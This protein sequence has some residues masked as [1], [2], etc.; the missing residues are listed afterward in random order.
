MN[1]NTVAVFYFRLSLNKGQEVVK[2]VN[3]YVVA[4]GVYPFAGKFLFSVRY[5]I[6]VR[7]DYFHAVGIVAD[8]LKRHHNAAFFLSKRRGYGSSADTLRLFNVR[9]GGYVGTAPLHDIKLYRAYLA[10]YMFRG[11]FFKI[12]S[13]TRKVFVPESIGKLRGKA[14]SFAPYTLGD[15]YNHSRLQDIFPAK[16]RSRVD[17][18]YAEPAHRS[19]S[20]RRR[21]QPA[22]PRRAP[23]S[24]LS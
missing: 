22:S 7:G 14:A 8:T 12:F 15:R 1:R 19:P 18:S 2:R 9:K 16:S 13:D 20:V 11:I 17:I 4:L 21:K 24:P 6:N 10:A 5:F 3:G 23:L